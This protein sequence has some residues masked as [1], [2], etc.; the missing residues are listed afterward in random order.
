MTRTVDGGRDGRASD[1]RVLGC[2]AMKRYALGKSC[3]R[4]FRSIFLDE[5]SRKNDAEN[6]DW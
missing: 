3:G 1:R 2:L 4:H 5:T 6:N